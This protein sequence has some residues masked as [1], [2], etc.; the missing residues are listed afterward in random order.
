MQME[1]ALYY[2]LST[3][4]QT[5]AGALGMLAA[6]LVL[7]V[8]TLDMSIREAIGRLQDT[9]HIHPHGG[10]QEILRVFQEEVKRQ[11]QGRG[12][13]VLALAHA[14]RAL[15]TRAGLLGAARAAFTLSACMMGICFI[16]LASSPW[17]ALAA[18]RA[19]PVVAFVILGGVGCLVW[20]GLIVRGALE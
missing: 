20:Y 14:D 3:V 18:W 15:Q 9:T 12:A 8:S 10:N 4:S 2:T 13:A 11:P 16:G 6:F 1:T 17:L 19:I 5:L 7:R